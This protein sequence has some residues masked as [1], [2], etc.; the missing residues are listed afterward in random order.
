MNVLTQK[1]ILNK[2]NYLPSANNSLDI[3]KKM[4]QKKLK[5]IQI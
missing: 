5:I 3:I 1:K 4:K 2:R